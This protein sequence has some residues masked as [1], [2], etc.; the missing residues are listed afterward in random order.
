MMSS[1]RRAAIPILAII[2]SMQVSQPQYVGPIY[3][4]SAHADSTHPTQSG[5]IFYRYVN[6]NQPGP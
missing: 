4:T 1:P 6:I 2:G 5:N 3:T